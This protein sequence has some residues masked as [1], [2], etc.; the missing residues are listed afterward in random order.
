MAQRWP[1]RLWMSVTA[2][3]GNVARA[4]AHALGAALIDID[5]RDVDV[6]LSRRGEEQAIA[7]GKWFASLLLGEA[8]WRTAPSRN[9]SWTK[10]SARL[11]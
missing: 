3:A 8:T 4:T 9:M 1:S 5:I 7:L 11:P 10:A 2:S 6:P